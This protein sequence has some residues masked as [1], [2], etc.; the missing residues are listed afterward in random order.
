MKKTLCLAGAVSLALSAGARALAQE[1]P[2]PPR[3]LQVFREEVKPGKGPAHAKVE[4]GWPAAF[5]K[6]NWPS[7]YLALAS[8]T[9]PSEAWFV[10]GYDSLAAWEKDTKAI[11]T[12]KALSAHLDALTEKDGELLSGHSGLILTHRVELDN[13]PNVDLSKMRYFRIATFRV[14]P[15]HD[16]DFTGAVKIVKDAYAKAKITLTWAVYQVTA[17]MP[18]PTYLVWI[19]MHSL[20]EVDAARNFQSAIMEAEGEEGRKALS[21]A[22]SD[23]YNFVTQNLF[24]ISPTMSYPPKEWAKMDPEFWAPK[25]AAA[26]AKA[27]K[28]EAKPAEKK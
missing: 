24:A 26:A 25:P 1:P 11:E 3:I 8:M 2:P 6:A 14:R 20:E 12:N 13:G 21:K 28:K 5:A 19:P 23:G 17:G 9:G 27:A 10:S 15:G 18:G 22:A 4:A 7:H 16:D